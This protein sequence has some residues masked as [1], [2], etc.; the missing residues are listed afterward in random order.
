MRDSVRAAGVRGDGLD[1]ATLFRVEGVARRGDMGRAAI[2]QGEDHDGGRRGMVL[3]N[4]DRLSGDGHAATD[5][6]NGGTASWWER[7]E[8]IAA[9][10]VGLGAWG[11]DEAGRAILSQVEGRQEFAA[12]D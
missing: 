12:R 1:P 8:E 10:L 11:Q 9:V 3:Y 4:L 2:R 7:D 6:D 5:I